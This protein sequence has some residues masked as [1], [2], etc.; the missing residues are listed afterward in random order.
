MKNGEF[1][2]IIDIITDGCIDYLDSEF[3]IKAV[4]KKIYLHEIS[5]INL[6]Y[7]SSIVT[8][9]GHI[10]SLCAFSYEKQLIDTLYKLF[11]DGIEIAPDEED[12]YLEETA[13]EIINIVIGNA[14]AKLEQPDSL[15]KVSPPFVLKEAKKLIN[16]K[17]SKFYNSIITTDIGNLNLFLVLQQES[18]PV[19]ESK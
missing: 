13:C 2:K 11:T 6:D 16:K 14:T 4:S 19:K 1:R 5:R 9:E 15:L 3:G 7:L 12:V 10:T 18:K 8:L 17:D